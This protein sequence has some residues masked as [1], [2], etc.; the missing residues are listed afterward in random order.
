MLT[1]EHKKKLE[2]LSSRS[3]YFSNEIYKMLL[4]STDFH[5]PNLCIIFYENEIYQYDQDKFVKTDESKFKEIVNNTMHYFRNTL[6]EYEQKVSHIENYVYKS[7][8]DSGFLDKY[9]KIKR[10]FS[11]FAILHQYFMLALRDFLDDF[12]SYKKDFKGLLEAL[13]RIDKIIK[14]TAERLQ[15][16][17]SYYNSLNE[18]KHNKN[19]YIL[20]VISSFFLPLNLITGFFGMNTG[21]MFFTGKHGTIIVLYA[22]IIILIGSVLWIFKPKT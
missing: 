13:K 3:G 20:T 7:K 17:F 12:P 11:I 4:I 5:S 14:D 8:F 6:D 10:N 16:I 15:I 2:K 22:I 19:L 21:D 1:N 18:K 9:F